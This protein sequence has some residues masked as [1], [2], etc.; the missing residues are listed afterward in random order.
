MAN[1]F[2]DN[3]DLRFY[4]EK[5]L[6]WGPLWE[7]SE[8]GPAAAD[9]GAPKDAAEAAELYRE[10][11]QAIG[12]LAADEVAPRAAEIDRQGARFE[13]GEA[14]D[15]PDFEAIFAKIRELDLHRMCLPRD[16]GG[17]NAP[18]LLYFVQSELLARGDV[19]VM[20]HH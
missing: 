17:L 20:A 11:A 10:I 6:A 16:L 12:E 14:H 5:G 18:L 3:D 15:P 7:A 8:Y 19:S 4:F 2:L 9:A 13:A 1:F